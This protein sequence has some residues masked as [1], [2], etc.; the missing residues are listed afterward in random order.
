M[1]VT[2]Y[3]SLNLIISHLYNKRR[4]NKRE[5]DLKKSNLFDY[6]TLGIGQKYGHTETGNKTEI[7]PWIQME[8]RENK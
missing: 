1:P 4:L 5:Y 6:G 8:L 2:I 7:K 3:N